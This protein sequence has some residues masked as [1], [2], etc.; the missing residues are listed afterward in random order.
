MRVNCSSAL[1]RGLRTVH[2]RYLLSNIQ[3]PAPTFWVP[4]LTLNSL[5]QEAPVMLRSP[6]ILLGLSREQGNASPT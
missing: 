4:L 6:F 5:P 3:L 1:S 2:D